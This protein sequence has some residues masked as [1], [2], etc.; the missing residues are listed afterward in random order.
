MD[1]ETTDPVQ[2][3]AHRNFNLLWSG[4]SLSLLGNQFLVIGLP[5]LAVQVV[6]ASAAQAV[7]LPF[8]MFVPF[9]FFGLPVGAWVDRLPKRKTMI[10]ADLVQMVVYASIALLS[11]QGWMTFPLL[12]VLV[13]CA[14]VATV[15]FQVAY[16][17][18]L[19]ELYS[20]ASELQK[21]NAKLFF[22]ESI[23]RTLGPMAAGPVIAVFAPP[24][25]I[26]LNGGSFLVSALTL[27]A[28]R[29][30]R[31]DLDRAEV[32]PVRMSIMSDIKAGLRFVFSHP[33]LEPVF[34]CGAVYVLF[35]TIIETSLVLY[36]KD[37]LMLSP[38]T[39][40][41]VIG[42]AAAGFPVANLISSRLMNHFGISRTLV[43]AAATSVCGLFLIAV[44]G[45]AGSIAGLIA[46][47]VLHGLGEGVFGPTS[48]T[49]RQTE[50][51]LTLLGRVNSVQR[52]MIW[53]AIPM[54]SVLTSLI[55]TY[56]GLEWTLWFGGIGT[57][58]CLLPLV[59][60]GI[61]ADLR[62]PNQAVNADV[63]H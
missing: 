47:S 18:F 46:A 50:T 49:L 23:A 14:G 34:L 48:L 62:A 60:R 30:Q 38:G 54:G 24:L 21:G 41:L 53:G 32:A 2:H 12:M 22:S 40:G 59:R 52:F 55:I 29:H 9:L 33:K 37:V 4:Q 36:C 3:A 42:A 43:I 17:S 31:T 15:F 35:L 61:L 25:A 51:P 6:G 8:L 45:A 7:L 27:G 10:L 20:R 13:F 57:A 28:I 1:A 19:P 56:A 26:L 58:L 16:N 63:T 44:F 5:L 39:I 11:M